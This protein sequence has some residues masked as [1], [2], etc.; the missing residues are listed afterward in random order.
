MI[1]HQQTIKSLKNYFVYVK[2]IMPK[3]YKEKKQKKINMKPKKNN[4]K[5]MFKSKVKPKLFNESVGRQR[6]LVKQKVGY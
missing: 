5:K 4:K 6:P 1:M 3:S 2:Y